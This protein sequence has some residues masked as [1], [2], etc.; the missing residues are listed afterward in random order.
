MRKTE[1]RIRL[2]AVLREIVDTVRID[3]RA[4]EHAAG[5]PIASLRALQVI[6]DSP[7]IRSSELAAELHLKRSTVSNLLRDLHREG[8]VSRVLLHSDRRGVVLKTTEKAC[9][10]LQRSGHAGQGLL[11]RAV[12]NL[13]HHEVQQLRKAL[14][15][16]HAQL[17]G[18]LQS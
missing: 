5:L 3:Y 15:P 13:T 10:T 6:N 4:R 2:T 1:D 11:A 7:G 18:A 16:L 8:L 17:N 12:A 9:R 14:S